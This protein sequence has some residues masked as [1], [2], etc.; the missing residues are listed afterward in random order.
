MARQGRSVS[1]VGLKQRADT[2]DVDA[3]VVIGVVDVILVV[4]SGGMVEEMDVES[5]GMSISHVVPAKGLPVAVDAAADGASR[6]NLPLP[7]GRTVMVKVIVVV[8]VR[9]VVEFAGSL[10]WVIGVTPSLGTAAAIANVLD[11]KHP[12]PYDAKKRQ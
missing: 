12:R 5:G 6:V 1:R 8:G 2:G 4:V 7:S 9:A 10:A 11:A 3:D